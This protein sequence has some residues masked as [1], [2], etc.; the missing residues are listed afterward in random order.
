MGVPGLSHE[1]R[2]TRPLPIANA[3][4][5][6]NAVASNYLFCSFPRNVTTSSANDDR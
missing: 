2:R 3:D 5:I 6:H 1:H 4:V